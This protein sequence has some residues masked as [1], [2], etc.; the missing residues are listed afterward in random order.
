M[1]EFEAKSMCILG[2]QPALGLSELESLYGAE[3]IRPIAG[4]ALLDIDAVDINFKRLGGTIKVARLLSVLP[5]T[6]WSQLLDY[7]KKTIPQH[8]Q[9]VSEGPFTLGLSLYGLSVPINEI[10]KGTLTIKRAVKPTGR[11]IRVVPNKNAELNAAQVLHNKL[12]HKG[13]WE[14]LLIRDGSQTYLAQTLFVQDIEAYAARDQARPKRDA[15]IGMLPPKLGQ[16]IINL[17]VGHIKSQ[18]S[19]RVRIL[20]PFCGTGV[21]LQEALLMGYSVLGT[22]SNERLIEYSKTNIRW[23]VQKY[24]NLSGHVSIEIGDAT[25]FK[26]PRFSAVASEVY[27]GRP[28]NN[29][30]DQAELKKI[31]NDVN[32]ITKKFLL[33]LAPQLKKGQK[34]S[35]AVPAWKTKTGF[36]YL[37]LIDHLTDMG[38]NRVQFQHVRREDLIYFREDQIVARELLVLEKN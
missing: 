26:W 30:P 19:S 27:L 1:S 3:H 10:N 23:L 34:V 38:Y 9:H 8:L 22:D 2:R 14:L 29:L 33:N 37:P 32:T 20:D 24:P 28:L 35:L 11:N 25:D 18:D 15:R 21:V 31:I 12:T 5:T 36:K 13:A 17:A 16:I 7:L 6:K 4:A